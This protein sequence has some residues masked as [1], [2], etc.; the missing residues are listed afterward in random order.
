ML[1]SFNDATW[2]ALKSSIPLP[3]IPI[4]RTPVIRII[5]DLIHNLLPDHSALHVFT[6]ASQYATRPSSLDRQYIFFARIVHSD[7]LGSD[8]RTI[9]LCFVEG[10]ICAFGVQLVGC[11]LAVSGSGRFFGDVEEW[12]EEGYG[13]CGYDDGVFD[14]DPVHEGYSVN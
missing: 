13:G 11:G 2:P 3:R 10:A 1:L 5:F 7:G 12:S 8:A 14:Y 6:S 4:I 9:V